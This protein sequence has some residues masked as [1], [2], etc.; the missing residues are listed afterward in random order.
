M[1]VCSETVFLSIV[2]LFRLVLCCY[3][4]LRCVLPGP[5]CGPIS[6]NEHVERALREVKPQLNALKEK[7]NTVRFTHSL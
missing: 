1:K 3:R 2:V 7:L 5:P 6:C 4:V